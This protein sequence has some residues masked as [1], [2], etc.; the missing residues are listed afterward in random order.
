M[1]SG[2]T[3]ISLSGEKFFTVDAPGRPGKSPG[4][5][6]S[7]SRQ[8]KNRK[9]KIPESFSRFL[10]PGLLLPGTESSSRRRLKKKISSRQGPDD[11]QT[12][13]GNLPSQTF[14]QRQ[15]TLQ[16][17]RHHIRTILRRTEDHAFISAFLQR[18]RHRSGRFRRREEFR[19]KERCAHPAGGRQIQGPL[20]KQQKR[21]LPG[22][23]GQGVDEFHISR[24]H[25]AQNIIHRP[26]TTVKHISPAEQIMSRRPGGERDEGKS[27]KQPAQDSSTPPPRRRQI[28]RRTEAASRQQKQQHSRR[29][30]KTSL[31]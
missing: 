17:F 13:R 24:I 16:I 9:E 12:S 3:F 29:Q 8:R 10:F 23:R 20:L 6:L 2:K 14:H 27:K 22:L 5:I 4:A 21:L 19:L 28:L 26:E 7:L 15:R 11:L 18:L 1:S 25:G 30:Q 31:L